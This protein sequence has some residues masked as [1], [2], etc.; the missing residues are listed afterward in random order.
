[1]LHTMWGTHIPACIAQ[2]LS[3]PTILKITIHKT[4]SIRDLDKKYLCI[5]LFRL[6]IV[7]DAK[8]HFYFSKIK[9]YF[10]S[11]M[12]ASIILDLSRILTVMSE[13]FHFF[14]QNGV[15]RFLTCNHYNTILYKYDKINDIKQNL[16]LS[17]SFKAI[18]K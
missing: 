18:H 13:F 1:M 17:S 15:F 7:Y 8:S 6:A 11:K 12:L 3:L 14:S 5:A 4:L 16:L 9:I 10:L 2:A